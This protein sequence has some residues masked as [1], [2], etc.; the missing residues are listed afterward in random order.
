MD[1]RLLPPRRGYL[2][3]CREQGAEA[4][5][6]APHHEHQV[7]LPQRDHQGRSQTQTPLQTQWRTLQ[8]HQSGQPLRDGEKAKSPLDQTNRKANI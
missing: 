6:G 7:R 2:P 4:G 5:D 3:Q 8:P 1:H